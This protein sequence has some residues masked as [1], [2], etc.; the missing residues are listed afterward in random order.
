MTGS[1]ALN[2]LKR[3]MERH[4]KI[5]RAFAIRVAQWIARLPDEELKRFTRALKKAKK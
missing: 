2:T 5:S 1:S 3:K 4:R